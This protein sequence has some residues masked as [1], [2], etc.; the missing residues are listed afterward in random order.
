MMECS[1]IAIYALTGE[2]LP[3]VTRT[4]AETV[5]AVEDLGYTRDLSLTRTWAGK[6]LRSLSGRVV[7]S[8]L[9]F[10]RGHVCPVVG[11]VVSNFCG[12]GDEPITVVVAFVAK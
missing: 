11:G 2:V 1:T 9:V 10:V 3:D 5:F 4:L 7:F 12:C 8:G 6:T